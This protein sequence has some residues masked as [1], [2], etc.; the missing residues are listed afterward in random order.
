MGNDIYDAILLY[1]NRYHNIRINLQRNIRVDD[2]CSSIMKHSLLLYYWQY[3][4]CDLI[5]DSTDRSIG[6]PLKLPGKQLIY[7]TIN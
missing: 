5:K 4:Q 6:Y 3:I 2:H 7:F 1:L